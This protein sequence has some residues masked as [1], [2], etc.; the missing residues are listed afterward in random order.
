MQRPQT[1]SNDNIRTINKIVTLFSFDQLENSKQIQNENKHNQEFHQDKMQNEKCKFQK[2][3]KYLQ[4][5]NLLLKSKN[6]LIHPIKQANQKKKCENGKFNNQDDLYSKN[7]LL[8]KETIQQNKVQSLQQI[9]EINYFNKDNEYQ[10]YQTLQQNLNSK[11]Q[12][13]VKKR[14]YST[15]KKQLYNFN[16]A[17]NQDKKIKVG[18][19]LENIN[20]G[21]IKNKQNLK[22][23]NDNRISLNNSQWE[24]YDNV[25]N[26][27]KGGHT[28]IQINKIIGN[29]LNDNQIIQINNNYSQKNEK[30]NQKKF[31]NQVLNKNIYQNNYDNKIIENLDETS[32]YHFDTQNSINKELSEE[33]L[34]SKNF[35]IEKKSINND[36]QLKQ[37]FPNL[38][39]IQI[40]K[41]SNQFNNQNN[42]IHNNNKS[43][44]IDGSSFLQEIKILHEIIEKQKKEQNLSPQNCNNNINEFNGQQQ[45]CSEQNNEQILDLLMFNTQQLSKKFEVEK[46]K[47]LK[48]QFQ[49]NQDK[50]KQYIENYKRDLIKNHQIKYQNYKIKI[51]NACWNNKNQISLKLNKLQKLNTNFPNDFFQNH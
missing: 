47:E 13:H 26:K 28:N 17:K 12:F 6:L 43:F 1:H 11:E 9:Q 23:Q 2:S 49:Q 27:D 46:I 22:D 44:D 39:Q 20:C 38:S 30:I 32:S 34:N 4:N 51:E 33:S 8:N 29:K 24:L 14:S 45:N 7:T 16:Q 36:L 3:V 35:Q 18:D 41:D 5:K 40:K 21:I 48:D 15:E 25:K 10:N 42:N 37:Q 31:Q 19:F 50:K